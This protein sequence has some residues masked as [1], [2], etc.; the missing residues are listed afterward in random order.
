MSHRKMLD[1]VQPKHLSRDRANRTHIHKRMDRMV[2]MG[3]IVPK[4]VFALPH[5]EQRA[6]D[7][8]LRLGTGGA[9]IQHGQG[10]DGKTEAAHNLPRDLLIGGLQLR[11]RSFWEFAKRLKLHESVKAQVKMSSA[12]TVNVSEDVNYVDSQWEKTSLAD[13]WTEYLQKCIHAHRSRGAAVLGAAIRAA[14][15]FKKQCQVSFGQA[16]ARIRE[17]PRIKAHRAQTIK[18]LQTYHDGID[19]YE[20]SVHLTRWWHIYQVPEYARAVNPQK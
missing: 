4:V 18:V 12:V 13:D 14:E 2:R 5:L 7:G 16:D 20:P 6:R 17:L 8:R 10:I 11:M 19:A 1:K 15:L 3:L 9:T